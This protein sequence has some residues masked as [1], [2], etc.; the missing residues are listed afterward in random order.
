VLQLEDA[1]RR[2]K[3]RNVG[4]EERPCPD[5]LDPQE[6][7]DALAWGKANGYAL[8]ELMYAWE[9]V[10]TWAHGKGAVKVDWV[11]AMQ[12]AVL[13]GWGRAG[14]GNWLERRK[15]PP[16][17]ITPELIEELVAKREAWCEEHPEP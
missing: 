11:A 1:R 10:K 3:R 17:T 14:Y 7:R 13:G 5:Y 12:N 16:R 2:R 6:L 15:R 8:E 9:R 4:K